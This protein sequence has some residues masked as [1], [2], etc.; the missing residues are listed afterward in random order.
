[1][2]KIEIRNQRLGDAKNFYRILA[3]PKFIYFLKPKSLEAEIKYLKGNTEKRKKKI[4]YNFTILYDEK[5]V[6]GI[7]LKMHPSRKFIGE[8][9]YFLDENY[10]GKGITLKALKLVEKFAFK[11]IKVR[12]IEIIMNPK[13]IASEKIAIKAGY[14]KEGT[15]KKSIQVNGHIFDA[16]L[17]AKIK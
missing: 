15:M 6:G 7:G 9:G 10:W 3:N 12:R 14:K 17:Y 4:E 16:H 1:M 13:N 8:I 5:I 11:K 2:P